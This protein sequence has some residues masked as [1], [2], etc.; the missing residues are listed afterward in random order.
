ME[1]RAPVGRR[2]AVDPRL[3]ERAARVLQAGERGARGLAHGE[4]HAAVQAPLHGDVEPQA[5]RDGRR[6]PA[7]ADDHR[8][9]LGPPAAR[10]H[11]DAAAAGGP[12]R[13]H[14]VGLQ[15]WPDGAGERP[16]GGRGTDGPALGVEDRRAVE[17]RQERQPGGDLVRPD[18]GR[19]DPRRLQGGEPP[20]RRGAE[21]QGA[22]PGH[23]L[24]AES[25]APTRG[26]AH[27][28]P[29]PSD[30]AGVVVGVAEEAL[31]PAGLPLPGT[32]RSNTRTVAPRSSAAYAV[33]RPTMPAPT[34]AMSDVAVTAAMIPR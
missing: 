18:L 2:G 24:G 5:A 20:L 9:V 12:E 30:E 32:P 23:Q 7:R 28:S 10:A 33:A 8:A 15:V 14:L 17:R 34:T 6:R 31:V 19:P 1:K 27:G 26:T 13:Q 11:L 25:L 3:A 29:S 22:V 21:E 4:G 16:D